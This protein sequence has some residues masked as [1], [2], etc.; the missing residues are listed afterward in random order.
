MLNGQNTNHS[1]LWTPMMHYFVFTL[2][3]ILLWQNNYLT[4]CETSISS[5]TTYSQPAGSVSGCLLLF[6][7]VFCLQETGILPVPGEAAP[8]FASANAKLSLPFPNLPTLPVACHHHHHFL[9]LTNSITKHTIAIFVSL[10]R[11]NTVP[12]NDM[13]S[14]LSNMMP[15]HLNVT[16]FCWKHSG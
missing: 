7:Y 16:Q 2:V 14:N 15:L 12:V 8:V 1:L 13:S 3:S 5:A 11:T 6:P 4:V 10:Y 9:H